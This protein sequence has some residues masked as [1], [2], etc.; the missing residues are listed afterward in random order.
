MQ[1]TSFALKVDETSSL[2]AE[3]TPSVLLKQWALQAVRKLK[4]SCI[5]VYVCL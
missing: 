4:V 1:V 3:M 2:L 5:G